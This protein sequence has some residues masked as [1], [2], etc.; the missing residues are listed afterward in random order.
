MTTQLK[1]KK[2]LSG[3]KAI[4]TKPP[5]GKPQLQDWHDIAPFHCEFKDVHELRQGEA[6]QS[7]GKMYSITYS[8]DGSQVETRVPMDKVKRLEITAPAVSADLAATLA[9]P[10]EPQPEKAARAAAHP[11][12]WQSTDAPGWERQMVAIGRIKGSATSPAQITGRYSNETERDYRDQ[13]LL[14]VWDWEKPGSEPHLF[15]DGTEHH[16]GDGHHTAQ[17][18][19]AAID[20]VE[21]AAI[22]IPP[23]SAEVIMARFEAGL[24]KL[25]TAIP[26][27]VTAGTLQDAKRY[28]RRE[29]NRFNGMRLTNEQKR[30]GAHDT[31]T[32]RDGL[33]DVVRWICGRTGKDFAKL[34]DAIPADRAVAEY[35][36]NVS[37]PT[38]AEVWELA[39]VADGAGEPQWPW[40]IAD[41]RLGLD[42][43]VQKAKAKPAPKAKEPTPPPQV[44]NLIPEPDTDPMAEGQSKTIGG[45]AVDRSGNSVGGGGVAGS[46]AAPTDK[47]QIAPTLQYIGKARL[48][49][50]KAIAAE[51]A[52]EIV[53]QVLQ[54]MKFKGQVE[55]AVQAVTAAIWEELEYFL[56]NAE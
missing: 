40:L 39:I 36:G 43:K 3:V 42:G 24:I 28:S 53:A 41:A 55:S 14:G 29:A 34:Q 9:P 15:W 6:R 23:N 16:T 20:W 56:D 50:I 37:A 22:A 21:T 38:M 17:A 18:L 27:Y 10:A 47:A 33:R 19:Q 13:M 26:C 12:G 52:Q 32:D 44:K 30:G 46:T 2:G 5:A 45:D 49:R 4:T 35:L 48:P 11:I 25:P 7:N 51:R 54:E 31:I 1:T 8:V